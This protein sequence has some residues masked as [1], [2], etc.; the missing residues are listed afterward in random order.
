[1]ILVDSKFTFSF[2]LKI[3]QLENFFSYF[4]RLSTITKSSYEP[5]S[6]DIFRCRVKTTGIYELK[7]QYTDSPGRKTYFV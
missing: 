5:T 4:D 3:K 1:M 2:L 7:F 6:E